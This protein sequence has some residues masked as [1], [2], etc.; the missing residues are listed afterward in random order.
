[1]KNSKLRNDLIA[2]RSLLI[3]Q[4]PILYTSSMSLISHPKSEQA[5]ALQEQV[6]SEATAAIDI[7]HK[8]YTNTSN[9]EEV[10]KTKRSSNFLNSLIDLDVTDNFD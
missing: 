8:V 2:A 6:F 1:M 3:K 5:K 4:N 9:S 10:N 7:I